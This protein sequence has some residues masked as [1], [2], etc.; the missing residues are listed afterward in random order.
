MEKSSG[1]KCA[2]FRE[3]G[4]ENISNR[5]TLLYVIYGCETWSVALREEHGLREF[6]NWVLRRIFWPV[7]DEVT[8]EWRRL[9]DEQLYALYSSPNVICDQ[10][11]QNEMARA[12]STYGGEERCLRDFG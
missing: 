11:K 8:G 10:I 1:K 4:R 7:R 5:H 6:E 12:C 2:K 3:G 9:H